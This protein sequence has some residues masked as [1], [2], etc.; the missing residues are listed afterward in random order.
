MIAR[1]TLKGCTTGPTQKVANMIAVSLLAKPEFQNYDFVSPKGTTTKNNDY[2]NL[3]FVN[4]SNKQVIVPAHAT[5]MSKEHAQDHAMT[6]VGLVSA[7][8]QKTYNDAACVESSQGG[9]LG[10]KV[11]DFTILPWGLRQL[12]T[13]QRSGHNYSKLWDGIQKF[14]SSS[15]VN[16]GNSHLSYF[17]DKFEKELDQFVAQFEVVP[18]QV[19]AIILIN[20]TV[21]GIERTPNAEYFRDIF[22]PLI[23]SCYGSA[24]MRVS[25]GINPAKTAEYVDYPH[26]SSEV[27]TIEDVTTAYEAAKLA[28][29]KRADEIINN[30]L[31]EI[32]TEKLDEGTAG[33]TSKTV[34]NKQLLGQTVITEDG[35]P[36]YTSMVVKREWLEKQTW[37]KAPMFEL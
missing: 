34:E 35:Q 13:I 26:V 36:V 2:G 15:G 30:L 12:A 14:N 22:K 23:R 3:T 5:Y 32:L 8:A 18:N 16:K 37:F 17:Y 7:N 10:A 9:T 19:G 24:A 29:K 27:E 33:I 25:Q 31:D 4:K 11:R 1:D 21:F 20:G 6:K 28:E